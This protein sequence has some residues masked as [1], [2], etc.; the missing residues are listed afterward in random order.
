MMLRNRRS[1][2]VSL[3]CLLLVLLSFAP[4]ARA[5]RTDDL[6]RAEMQRRHIPGLALAVIRDG[7]IVK[8]QGYGLASVELNVPVT[9]DTVFEIGSVTKQITAAAIMLLVQDGKLRLD[10]PV[11]RHLPGTPASWS[12][13]TVRHLLTHTSGIRNYTGLPG[14][15]LSRRLKRDDFIRAIAGFPLSFAPGESWSYSNT[16]YNL[17]GLIIAEVSG[18]SY[19]QFVTE[20]IFRPLGMNA[21]RDRDPLDV[22]PLRANGYERQ[23]DMLRGRDY[24]LTDV[25][26]AG[27]IVSTVMDLARWD[28]AL[29]SE[30]LLSRSS[31]EQIWTPA[32]LNNG[33]PH[34]YGLGWYIEAL[35]GQRVI[36]HSGQTAGF[37]ASLARYPDS[38]LTV[39]VLCNL[40]EL[41]I[42]GRI[43]LGVAKIYNPA[44][45][46]RALRAQTD[47]DPQTTALLRR[48]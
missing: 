1:S 37:A 26:S 18:Q 32:R 47:P 19:W 10:D 27:A 22:I 9:T 30:R 36:R 3:P 8:A 42:A 6:I 23:N 45:S 33:N 46:L 34:P 48:A 24:D 11:S 41:G 28:A 12:S 4:T 15:E 16:G 43:G 20:R 17:L 29:N 25:F 39:I 40:G 35:R 44:L 21:T 5:D 31:L 2:V 14:F 13:I 7:R 38:R